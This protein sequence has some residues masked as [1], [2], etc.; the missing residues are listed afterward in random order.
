MCQLF[1]QL[2]RWIS[3]QTLVHNSQDVKALVS[4]SLLVFFPLVWWTRF[5]MSKSRSFAITGDPSTSTRSPF[6]RGS[7]PWR[8]TM[9]WPSPVS[10]LLMSRRLLHSD[11]A[12]IQGLKAFSICPL[13]DSRLFWWIISRLPLKVLSLRGCFSLSYVFH[14][15]E[16]VLQEID[17]AA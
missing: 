12:P 1:P 2:G 10:R 6:F 16:F 13:L 9:T 4:F 15:L 17:P 11:T 5:Q 3:I 14:C 8:P 7:T